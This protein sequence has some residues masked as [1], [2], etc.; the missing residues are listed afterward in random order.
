MGLASAKTR[1]TVE[2]PGAGG[3]LSK[4][5][6][7]EKGRINEEGRLEKRKEPGCPYAQRIIPCARNSPY[8]ASETAY[9]VRY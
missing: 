3:D 4:V 1:W 2:S 5:G 8:G 6:T 9:G 7:A